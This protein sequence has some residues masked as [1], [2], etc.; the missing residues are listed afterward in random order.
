MKLC[1]VHKGGQGKGRLQLVFWD[2]AGKQRGPILVFVYLSI[3]QRNIRFRSHMVLDAHF[4][5]CGFEFA[6]TT[7]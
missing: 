4:W 3:K 5:G 7:C 1:G 6:L 2:E